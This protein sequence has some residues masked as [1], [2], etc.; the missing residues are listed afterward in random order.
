MRG[1]AY[2][3]RLVKGPYQGESCRIVEQ[4]AALP[5]YFQ[6]KIRRRKRLYL[7]PVL[8]IV[9]LNGGKRGLSRNHK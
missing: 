9:P 2:T 3:H 4:P 8:W 1:P 6:V 7:F 5:D